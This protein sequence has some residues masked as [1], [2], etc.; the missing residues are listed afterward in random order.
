MGCDF[1]KVT[2]IDSF[3]Q[4]V[5]LQIEAADIEEL[6]LLGAPDAVDNVLDGEHKVCGGVA[7][8]AEGH[9][10]GL[11]LSDG[12]K[13]QMRR[14]RL[15]QDHVAAKN[16]GSVGSVPGVGARVEDHSFPFVL[17]FS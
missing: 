16:A 4:L 17:L 13:G 2:L 14:P 15:D 11:G 7:S 9:E 12:R 1:V 3:V 10:G 8:I 6:L 5:L